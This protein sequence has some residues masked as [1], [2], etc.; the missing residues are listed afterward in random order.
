MYGTYCQWSVDDKVSDSWYDL[1]V[2]G[3]GQK[4]FILHVFDIYY[5]ENSL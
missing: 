3:H 5:S 2:K 4:Y 1:G